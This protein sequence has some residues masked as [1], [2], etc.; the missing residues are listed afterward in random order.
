LAVLLSSKKKKGTR[1]CAKVAFYFPTGAI[2]QSSFIKSRQA[3]P[4][5]CTRTHD[6]VQYY[7]L[8]SAKAKV[9]NGFFLSFLAGP[10][11]LPPS[12]PPPINH[13]AKQRPKSPSVT[14]T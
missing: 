6:L 13:D 9:M 2:D 11:S 1:N 7:T 10:S 14:K 3:V 12:P 5:F 8:S 4:F